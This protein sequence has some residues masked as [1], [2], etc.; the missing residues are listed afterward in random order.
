[1]TLVLVE[2]ADEAAMQRLR[3]QGIRVVG[4]LT[5]PLAVETKPVPAAPRK[6]AGALAAISTTSA[7]EWDRYLHDIRNEWERDI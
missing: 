1:M 3:Q 4:V 2:V 6:W 7:E 5:E